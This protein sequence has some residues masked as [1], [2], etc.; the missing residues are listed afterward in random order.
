MRLEGKISKVAICEKCQGFILACH[1]DYLDKETEKQ[2]TELTND[3]FTIKLETA[4]ETRSR[5]F[6][7]SKDCLNGSCSQAE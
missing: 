5:S 6:T 3:G 7:N 1:V 2:F 4:E